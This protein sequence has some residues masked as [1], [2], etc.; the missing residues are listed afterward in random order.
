MGSVWS[1]ILNS[2]VDTVDDVRAVASTCLL[3]VVDKLP[4]IIPDRVT[5][6]KLI[7][8]MQTNSSPLSV[9]QIGDAQTLND[10]LYG[11]LL[12]CKA[13]LDS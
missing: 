2:I 3:P 10:C 8:N 11:V 12:G 7:N 5:I 1:L 13:Y 6:S 4:T 9:N